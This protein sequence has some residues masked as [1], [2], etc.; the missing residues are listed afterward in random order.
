MSTPPNIINSCCSFCGNPATGS[1]LIAGPP[2]VFICDGCVELCADIIGQKELAPVNIEEAAAALALAVG[3]RLK[4]KWLSLKLTRT[5]MAIAASMDVHEIGR[6]EGGDT[7][8]GVGAVGAYA[9]AMGFLPMLS[10]ERRDA[11][12]GSSG[13]RPSAIS[14]FVREATRIAKIGGYEED[15][16]VVQIIAQALIAATE[17]AATLADR[18]IPYREH[19]AHLIAAALRRN[20]HLERIDA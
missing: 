1:K 5:Q 11:Q 3:A 14:P 18:Y 15:D 12:R 7:N 20:E 4:L 6:I 2:G 17:K 13:Q 19:Q 8:M 16:G 9:A 10:L